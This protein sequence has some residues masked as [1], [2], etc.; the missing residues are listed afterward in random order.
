MSKAMIASTGQVTIPGE[1]S[2]QLELSAGDK[3]LFEVEEV[4]RLRLLKCSSLGDLKGSLVAV[5]S[6]D[7]DFERLGVESSARGCSA[8]ALLERGRLA[9]RGDSI[10]CKPE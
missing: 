1:V 4:I 9:L 10:V 3:L 8:P 2:E 5:A 6:F 7:R